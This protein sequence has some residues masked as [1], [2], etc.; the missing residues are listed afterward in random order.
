MDAVKV[1]VEDLLKVLKE[2][3]EKHV[4]EYDEAIVGYRIELIKQFKEKL[5]QAERNLDV[6]HS[7]KLV[8]PV[9]YVND[10]DD[11]IM[12]M[13]WTVDKEVELGRHEFL[14]YVNDSWSWKNNF[15]NISSSYK[16]K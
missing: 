16:S 3:R 15:S 1:A 2:N 10:Y 5:N 6:E 7:L 9:T 12:M 4:K 14:Q 8:R 13:E 11:A